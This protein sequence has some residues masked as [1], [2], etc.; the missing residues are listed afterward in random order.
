MFLFKKV[1]VLTG[2]SRFKSIN[3]SLEECLRWSIKGFWLYCLNLK[4]SGSLIHRRI[5]GNGLTFGEKQLIKTAFR[6]TVKIIPFSLFIIVPFAE[7]GLPFA[8]RLFPNMLPSTFSPK[9]IS[10]GGNAFEKKKIELLKFYSNIQS[11]ISSLKN[12]NDLTVNLKAYSM[13]R[14]QSKLLEGGELDLLELSK[15]VSGSYRDG[16]ELENLDFETLMSVSKVMGIY[17][18][19]SRFLLILQI[20]YKLLKLKGEDRDILYD[21]IDKLNK[22]LLYMVLTSSCHYQSSFGFKPQN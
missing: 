5:L 12:S 7:F 19:R 3:K 9:S 13:E 8:I 20:R 11:I 4:R 15:V 10:E 1:K 22:E 16:F 6:D 21:G 18:V 14:I 17:S 2:S